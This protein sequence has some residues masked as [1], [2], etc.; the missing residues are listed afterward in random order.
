MLH[1]DFHFSQVDVFGVRPLGG[2]ALAVVHEADDLT[3]DTMAAFARW[4][5]LAET[6]FLQTPQHPDADYRVRIW[7]TGGE[8]DFAGHPTL[9]SAH[10][11]LETGGKPHSEGHVVQECGAGLVTVA[12]RTGGLEFEAPPL[13]RSGDVDPDHLAIAITALGVTSDDVVRAAWVDNGPGWLGVQLRSA[14]DVLALHPDID[15]LSGHQI[16]AVGL[17]EPGVGFDVEIRAFYSDDMGCFEDPVTGSATAGVAQWLIPLDVLPERFYV[18][19]GT[20][21][22]REGRLSVRQEDGAVW[23]GGAC[24]TAI[25]G[26]VSFTV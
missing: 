8:L 25:S 15:D 24:V 17:A 3:D 10:A 14:T 11:W 5:N 23:V 9:G 18:R 2:N 4:T 16:V 21:L 13:V 6:V 7:T 12:R 19:Q 26:T 22:Q 20:A 1:N